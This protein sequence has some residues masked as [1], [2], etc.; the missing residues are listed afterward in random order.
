MG[1]EDVAFETNTDAEDL[2]PP[3]FDVVKT[4]GEGPH[5]TVLGKHTSGNGV[6]VVAYEE[7]YPY[8]VGA[9]RHAYDQKDIHAEFWRSVPADAVGLFEYLPNRYALWRGL[10]DD[11]PANKWQPVQ[12]VQ[13]AF[14]TDEI[15]HD[16]DTL[17]LAV[18]REKASLEIQ[19]DADSKGEQECRN[20][21]DRVYGMRYEFTLV[22]VPSGGGFEVDVK[23]ARA[24][25]ENLAS[26]VTA[27]QKGILIKPSRNSAGFRGSTVDGSVRELE[28]LVAE[29][30]GGDVNQSLSTERE[31]VHIDDWLDG[32]PDD[33][34]ADISVASVGE[35]AESMD[36]VVA[37]DIPGAIESLKEAREFDR[38]RESALAG[39]DSPPKSRMEDQSRSIDRSHGR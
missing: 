37:G 16:F 21:S 2:L 36:M 31:V 17:V 24:F 10:E 25:S 5:L 30:L 27:F 6:F 15:L 22:H 14:D 1:C 32:M 20:E 4:A 38:Q 26:A 28:L 19:R 33:E 9:A 12:G 13:V 35:H 39:K 7:P 8:V 23:K 3:G 34:L 18:E 29:N 11:H